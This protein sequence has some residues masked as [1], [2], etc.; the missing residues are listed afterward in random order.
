[1]RWKCKKCDLVITHELLNDD[2]FECHCSIEEDWIELDKKTIEEYKKEIALL[3]STINGMHKIGKVLIDDMNVSEDDAL[4]IVSM[5]T[6]KVAKIK[7]AEIN[8]GI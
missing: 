4:S 1:M 2:E 3:E 8:G 7:K 6:T 5:V